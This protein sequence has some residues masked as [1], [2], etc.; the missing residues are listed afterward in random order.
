L[1]A[2]LLI[3]R[4]FHL[5]LDHAVILLILATYIAFY[6][7]YLTWTG[8]WGVG[9]RFMIPSLALVWLFAMK[10][11]RRFPKF[12]GGLI[13]WSIFNMLCV[14]AV[15]PMFPAPNSGPPTDVDPVSVCRTHFLYGELNQSDEGHNLAS[16]MEV[17]GSPQLIPI[18]LLLAGYFGYAATRNRPPLA[19]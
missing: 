19:A 17:S 5:R 13:L 15:K 18:Y 12:S 8:G 14:T 6:L 2:L 10:P 11:A 7:T 4:P 9:L 1:C 3:R 16:L